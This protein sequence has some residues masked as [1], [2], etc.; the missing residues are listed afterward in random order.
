[1]RRGQP[2]PGQHF[3]SKISKRPGQTRAQFAQFANFAAAN[4]FTTLWRL[5]GSAP[6]ADWYEI[7]LLHTSFYLRDRNFR[8]IPPFRT[9]ILHNVTCKIFVWYAQLFAH[10]RNCS[11][12]P[13]SEQSGFSGPLHPVQ[14]YCPDFR[15]SRLARLARLVRFAPANTM[16]RSVR[17]V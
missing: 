6:S 13:F 12:Q 17:S 11:C 1:M 16:C 7:S 5:L 14:A 2:G 4:S 15:A 8:P 10:L 9:R 3:A